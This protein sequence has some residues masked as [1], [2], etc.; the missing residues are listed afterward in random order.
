VR[1]APPRLTIVSCDHA[2]LS[3]DVAALTGYKIEHLILADLFP[4]TYHLETIAHLVR[5]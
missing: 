4:Q 5:A 2:T 1:L 3:R